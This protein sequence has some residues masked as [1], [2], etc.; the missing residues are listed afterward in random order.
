MESPITCEQ[1]TKQTQRP[2]QRW[3]NVTAPEY[4]METAQDETE[5]KV[6]MTIITVMNENE[7]E[8]CECESE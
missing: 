7:H 1:K 8:N 3:S 5:N 4:A 6:K 2:F